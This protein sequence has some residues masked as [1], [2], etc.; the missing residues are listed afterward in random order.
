MVDKG[1]FYAV[2]LARHRPQLLII[3]RTL[4]SLKF[5]QPF[6][7]LVLSN[8]PKS[9]PNNR[10]ANSVDLVPHPIITNKTNADQ[11]RFLV[12]HVRIA[13]LQRA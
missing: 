10:L 7:L 5:S 3:R 13:Q 11:Q 2:A 6:L 1:L 12:R 4:N 9:Q 8:S